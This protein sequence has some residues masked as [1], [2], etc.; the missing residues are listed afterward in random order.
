[1][2]KGFGGLGFHKIYAFNIVM[3]GKQGMKLHSNRDAF[4]S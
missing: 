4:I 3:L 1:M 2:N